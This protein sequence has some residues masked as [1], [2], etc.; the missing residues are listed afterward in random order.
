M[1]VII[2]S[3]IK[4]QEKMAISACTDL[5]DNHGA[6]WRDEQWSRRLKKKKK[7]KGRGKRGE[8]VRE[9]EGMRELPRDPSPFSDIACQMALLDWS[10][11]SFWDPCPSMPLIPRLFSF[12]LLCNVLL[13]LDLMGSSWELNRSHNLIFFFT[14]TPFL[15][16]FFPSFFVLRFL[17]FFCLLFLSFLCFFFLYFFFPSLFLGQT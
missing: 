2:W 16:L 15:C 7:K 4:H 5:T 3:K 11:F 13:L 6:H 17:Y 14:F 8:N 12:L 1:K 9:S 10:V